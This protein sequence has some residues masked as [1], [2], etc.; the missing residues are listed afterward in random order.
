[1]AFPA[2]VCANSSGHEAE[3]I[4]AGAGE[5]NGLIHEP[6]GDG[7]IVPQLLGKAVV[8]ER[9]GDVSGAGGL[10]LGGQ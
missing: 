10:R 9:E 4:L 2:G 7:G 8:V 3:S 1:M 5:M 6:V